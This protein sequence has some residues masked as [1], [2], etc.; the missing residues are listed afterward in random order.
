[1]LEEFDYTLLYT[2]GND[3]DIANIISHCTIVDIESTHIQ[4][5]NTL[6]DENIV[7]VSLGNIKKNQDDSNLNERQCIVRIYGSE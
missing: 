5:M 6:E 2:P 4:E 7:P 3:N 1:M